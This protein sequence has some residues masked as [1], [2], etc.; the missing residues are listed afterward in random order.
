MAFNT[1]KQ[2]R[3]S[4]QTHNLS[5]TRSLATSTTPRFAAAS[6]TST[7]VHEAHSSTRGGRMTA[8]FGQM[9]MVIGLLGGMVGIAC[10][11]GIHTAKQQLLHSPSVH[12]SKKRRES[13][14]EVDN[15]D[16][17]IRSSDNFTNKSFLRK[18]G[19]IQDNKL[20]RRPNSYT[21]IEQ[22]KL[23][24]ARAGADVDADLVTY[25]VAGHCKC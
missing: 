3:S 15:P 9:W 5:I 17:I 11:M 6:A 19:H 16:A 24:C 25:Y 10:C 2:C 4:M 7:A 18:V 20:G 13:V 8:T 14:P 23:V 12:V 21:R 22:D 1:L